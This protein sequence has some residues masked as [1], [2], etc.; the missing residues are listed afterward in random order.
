MKIIAWLLSPKFMLLYSINLRNVTEEEEKRK[1]MQEWR[2]R[3]KALQCEL[4]GLHNY[5]IQELTW[6]VISSVRSEQDWS[7]QNSGWESSLGIFLTKMLMK[8]DSWW[9]EG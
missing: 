9:E 4:S 3:T 2:M 1:R 6:A 8:V 5:Y 7:S